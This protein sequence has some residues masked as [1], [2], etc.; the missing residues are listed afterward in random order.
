[1]AGKPPNLFAASQTSMYREIRDRGLSQT[2][3]EHFRSIGAWEK[4]PP[5]VREVISIDGEVRKIPTGIHVDGMLYYNTKVAAAAGVDPRRWKTLDEMFADTG[6]VQRAGYNF[7]AVGGNTFQAGYLFHALLAAVGGRRVFYDF[8]RD[9]PK[10]SVFEAPELR[11]TIELFRRITSQAD[12]G[13]SNR[14]WAESTNTVISGKTLMHYH[15]DWMKGQ[16]KAQG[17]RL[18]A[19]FNCI[20]LPGAKALSVTVDALGILGG[21]SVTP[22]TL[23][24]ELEFATVVVDPANN[25]AFAARKGATPVRTDAPA[26]GL[27]QCNQ[28]V[29]NSLKEADSSV[30]NPFYVGDGDWINSVWNALYTF[31]CAEQ[32]STDDLI[33]RLY[34]E[35]RAIFR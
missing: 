10:P 35:Y 4:F 22:E 33:R 30:Q 1:L 28:L 5:I 9:T 32:M 2:L 3:G 29:L 17:K 21:K 24:A 20:N 7:M 16:W 11:R 14:S 25:G 23:Q 34:S 26:S 31:Q 13:W 19:D 12:P 18:G 27:D 15:G 6:K 8:F